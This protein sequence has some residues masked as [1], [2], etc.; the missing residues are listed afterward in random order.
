M[1][2]HEEILRF[3]RNLE[4]GAKVSVRSVAAS[5]NV[6][7]GT[8]YRA[9]KEAE[10][11]GLV[12]TVP[13]V[14]T[15][16]IK[17]IE[18]KNIETL[19]YGEVINIVDGVALGGKEGLYKTLNKF[20]IGAMTIDAMEKYMSP[21]SLIIVGNREEVFRFAIEKGC[22]VLIT[23]GFGCPDD[24]KELANEN[25]LPIISS[26]YDTFTIATLINKAISE[27]L[28]KKDIVLVEDIMNPTPC[29]LHMGDTVREW[30]DI[31]SSTGYSK[32]PVLD[33]RG[34]L[35]G[36]VTT[37]DFTNN[38]KDSDTLCKIMTRGPVTVSKKASIA[39]AANIMVWG[40]LELIPVV[41]NKK[42]VGIISRGDVLKALQHISRQ[43]HVSETFEDMIMENF[44]L[45]AEDDGIIFSGRIV[46]EM[47]NPV[48]TASMNALT[49]LMSM[50]C[51]LALT[52]KN[53]LNVFIDSFTIYN[54][55]PVQVDNIISVHAKVMDS[56]RNF[57]KVDG[58]MFDD[59]GEMCS[60][61]MLSAK[62]MK[63]K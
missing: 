55:K 56:G 6:S 30:K 61:C 29:Y 49:M 57:A 20:I 14:G 12:S 46:P 27:R 34:R 43:P 9:I 37:K 18:K 10:N 8:A 15:V 13:R 26:S 58:V 5:L 25:K 33:D 31:M 1:T 51:T 53:H 41:D 2:K 28:I 47:Y 21:G 22:A 7:E 32:F 16:R 52:Q 44:T 36:V 40:S 4:I 50:V 48:G 39:H 38:V 35:A 59:N 24:V 60:K 17:K 23:G 42:L 54:M 3:I 63:N 45:G 11:C 62:I 19:T